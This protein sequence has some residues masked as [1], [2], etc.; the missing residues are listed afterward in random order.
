MKRASSLLTK[1]SHGPFQKEY[2]AHLVLADIY[3]CFVFGCVVLLSVFRLR[4][5]S[6]GRRILH[7]VVVTI[8]SSAKKKSWHVTHGCNIL[9]PCFLFHTFSPHMFCFVFFFFFLVTWQRS[10]INRSLYSSF[11]GGGMLNTPR[12]RRAEAKKRKKKIKV[13]CCESRNTVDIRNPGA[14]R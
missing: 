8:H 13:Q 14:G 12:R 5:P 1:K 4:A 11:P 3:T 9:T 6:E 7:R 10:E 2:T